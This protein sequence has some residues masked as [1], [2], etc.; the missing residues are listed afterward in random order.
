VVEQ[1]KGRSKRWAVLQQATP[2]GHNNRSRSEKDKTSRSLDLVGHPR[3]SLSVMVYSV[4]C[5]PTRKN[6]VHVVRLMEHSVPVL[7]CEET[8]AQTSI[9]MT[10]VRSRDSFSRYTSEQ[11]NGIFFAPT[12]V[13]L[14]DRRIE[15]P[16]N[17]GA[18]FESRLTSLISH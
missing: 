15:Q 11:S 10:S 14:G 8:G 18:L 7:P 12:Q 9:C 3:C 1:H 5:R 17:R 6:R 4:A 16:E 13:D 2:N